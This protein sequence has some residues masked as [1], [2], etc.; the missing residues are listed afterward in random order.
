[1]LSE[2]AGLSSIVTAAGIN[3][4]YAIICIVIGIVAMVIGYKIFDVLTP[5]NTAL[6]LKSG[7]IAA[8]IFNGLVALGIGICSGLVIGMSCN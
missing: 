4:T 6:E 5:F 1:M 8:A 2:S 3:I 7:N